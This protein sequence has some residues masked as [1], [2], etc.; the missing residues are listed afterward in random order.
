MG[1]EPSFAACKIAPLKQA[2]ADGCFEPEA[3]LVNGA[4]SD[5]MGN[6]QTIAAGAKALGHF[7]KTGHSPRKDEN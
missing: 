3:D 4:A 7:P 6:E 2:V 5:S 1:S